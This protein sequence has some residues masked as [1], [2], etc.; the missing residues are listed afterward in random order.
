[1]T[2]FLKAAGFAI[3]HPRADW[4]IATLRDGELG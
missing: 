3:D 1:V 2:V 4:I